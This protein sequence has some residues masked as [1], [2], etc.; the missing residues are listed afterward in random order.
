MKTRRYGI[1]DR[2]KRRML[3]PFLLPAL[4][5]YGAITLYPGISTFYMSVMDWGGVG[6]PVFI[7]L[8]N[9][10]RLVRDPTLIKAA[11]NTFFYVVVG[12]FILFP[13]AI[14]FALATKSLRRG[15]L[16]RFLIL[17]PIALSVT[18]AALLWKFAFN[19]NFG[20]VGDVFAALGLEALSSWEWLGEPS[21]ALFIVVLASVWHGIGIWMLFFISAIERVPPELR[22]AAILDGANAFQVFRHITFPLIWEMTRTLIILWIIQASQAFGFIIAMTNGGPLGATEVIGTYLYKQ[23]FVQF[24]YGYAAAVAIVL[25]LVVVTLT[26]ISRRIGRR[27]EGVEY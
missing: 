1:I 17:A 18:T 10:T 3:I 6:D 2:Q 26:V 5:L 23:A 9:F 25:S 4:V 21:T 7:G 15:K 14:T 20:F 19:P 12:G 11:G 27:G 22:E 24:E 13:L 16:Y 8:D